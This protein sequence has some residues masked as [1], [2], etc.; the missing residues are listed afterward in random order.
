MT[1]TT[2]GLVVLTII[3]LSISNPISN[4]SWMNL[5]DQMIKQKISIA[6]HHFKLLVCLAFSYPL[7]DIL[8]RIPVKYVF[9][10]N[11]SNI[12]ISVFF[13]IFILDL[14][15]GLQ[16][17]LIST[18]GTYII[19]KYTK[20]RYMPF[21]AFIFLMIHL[22]INHI[23]RQNGNISP[24]KDVTSIQMVLCMKLSAFAW[25]VYDGQQNELTLN[26][27]QK[28]YALKEL[29]SLFDYLG[30]VFFFPSFFVGPSFDLVDYYRWLVRDATTSVSK[31]NTSN[32]FHKSLMRKDQYYALKKFFFGLFYLY[33][34]QWMGMRYSMTFVFDDQFFEITPIQ[35]LFY[36]I[37]LALTHR[38]KYYG[39]WQFA[40]G[41]CVL[42]GLGE[43][44]RD[45]HGNVIRSSLENINPYDFETAQSTKQLLEA[46]NKCANRWLKHYVYLRITSSNKKPNIMSSIITFMISALWHGFYP[47]Y[48]LSF[49]TG[50]FAQILGRYLRRYI[51]P[52]FLTQDMQPTKYKIIYDILSWITTQIT[53]AYIVQPFVL[54]NLWDSLRFWQRYYV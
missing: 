45:F 33:I 27:K 38:F 3:S 24:E 22:S 6:I 43:S 4:S 1:L 37:L 8:R 10:R 7:A 30:Y 42:S 39:I 35:R 46:W 5:L 49:M 2:V 20:G 32:N 23:Y 40:E 26:P 14:W 47:G 19:V 12:L 50:A 15:Y 18:T 41:A 34:F 17:V 48:Y 21:I 52:F 53:W 36:L 9:I 11:F 44:I 25:N 54:L 31:E 13:L 16:T 28:K 29:P 51:R